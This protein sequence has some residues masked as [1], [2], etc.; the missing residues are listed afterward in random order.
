[1]L[2]G[3][4]RPLDVL[5]LRCQQG[6]TGVQNGLGVCGVEIVFNMVPHVLTV[7]VEGVVELLLGARFVAKG[8]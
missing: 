3:P 6:Q 7:M 8:L 2:D 1:M 4:C 5:Y